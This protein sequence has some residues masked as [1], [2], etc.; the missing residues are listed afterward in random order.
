MRKRVVG[1]AQQGTASG[2]H[3]WLDVEHLAE[4]EMTSENTSYPIESALRPGEGSGWRATVPGKQTIRLLFEVPQTIRRI[5][6][7]F[8]ETTVSR[9][10]EYVLRWSAD[11]GQS[12]REIVRQQ[13][14]FNPDNAAAETEEHLVE[15]V[16]VTT[17]ELTIVPDTSGGNTLA[18]LAQFRLA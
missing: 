2:A 13:W 15:L 14:N 7:G 12:L 11:G 4:V 6:L 5:R 16:G 18:T 8:V 1:P 10:Q 9:T 17:L 3:D